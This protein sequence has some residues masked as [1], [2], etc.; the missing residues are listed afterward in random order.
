MKNPPGN[1]DD[2]NPED[3]PVES[4]IKGELK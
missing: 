4:V 3:Y 2:S 1:I